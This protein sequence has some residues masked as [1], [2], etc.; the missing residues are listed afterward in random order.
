MSSTISTMYQET[1]R[2][3]RN[4]SHVEPRHPTRKLTSV[5]AGGTN[6]DTSLPPPRLIARLK[7]AILQ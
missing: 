1:R 7:P 6:G 2:K 3:R 5:V 4:I